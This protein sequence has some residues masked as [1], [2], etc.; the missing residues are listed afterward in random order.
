MRNIDKILFSN[1]S[2]ES[3]KSFNS[4]FDMNIDS[5]TDTLLVDVSYFV[6]KSN[7]ILGD[8]IIETTERL[9]GVDFCEKTGMINVCSI[10]GRYYKYFWVRLDEVK[11]ESTSVELWKINDIKTHIKSIKE[12]WTIEKNTKNELKKKKNKGK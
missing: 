7:K 2:S 11:A 12:E 6:L 4:L 3:P 10:D 1:D 9:I 5:D 8:D